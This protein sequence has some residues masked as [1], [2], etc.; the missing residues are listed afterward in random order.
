MTAAQQQ[1]GQQAGPEHSRVQSSDHTARLQCVHIH[2]V[3]SF[4][5]QIRANKDQLALAR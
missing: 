3:E 5:G 4:A 2:Q 1:S